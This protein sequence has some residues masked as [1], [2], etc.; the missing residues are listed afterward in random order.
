MLYLAMNH[1]LSHTVSVP[2][3]SQSSQRSV[4]SSDR[5]TD[6]TSLSQLNHQPQIK[7]P[8]VQLKFRQGRELCS[9][10]STTN[11]CQFQK[12]PTRG[13]NLGLASET[14]TLQVPPGDLQGPCH[15]SFLPPSFQVPKNPGSGCCSKQ[16]QLEKTQGLLLH[17]QEQINVQW[18]RKI[19]AYAQ[20]SRK[21]CEIWMA[22][23]QY[24]T[25]MTLV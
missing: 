9:S 19:H 14:G 17:S 5:S 16:D 13:K 11:E 22:Y 12:E 7:S 3:S 6:D 1:S 25:K 2:S 21:K 15:P 24:L 10:P 4:W 23:H 18:L 20:H 8:S